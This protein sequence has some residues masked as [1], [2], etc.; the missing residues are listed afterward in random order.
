MRLKGV[1]LVVTIPVAAMALW[2]LSLNIAIMR[3]R[4]VTLAV[5]GY[6]PRDLLSGHYLRYRIDY[7]I[8]P[9]HITHA[10]GPVCVCL[11]EGENGVAKGFWMGPCSERDSDN[12][13]VFIRGKFTFGVISAGIERYYIPEGYQRSLATL[14]Q[15]ATVK[16]RVA[17]DGTAYVTDMYVDGIPVLEWA[18]SPKGP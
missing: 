6:D 4:E 8:T 5:T 2:L 15:N 17:G 18:R 3:A 1:Y 7:G 11:S 12:C 10:G 16:A 9:D 13:P 14:P